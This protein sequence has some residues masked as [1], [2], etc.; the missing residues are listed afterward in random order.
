[1]YPG[2]TT[3]ASP[4]IFERSP[5]R[6]RGAKAVVRSGRDHGME[7]AAFYAAGGIFQGGPTAGQNVVSAAGSPSKGWTL[8]SMLEKLPSVKVTTAPVKKSRSIC[9]PLSSLLVLK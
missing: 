3:D 7:K 4:S 1:M 2:W 6:I 9:F 5:V 8:V